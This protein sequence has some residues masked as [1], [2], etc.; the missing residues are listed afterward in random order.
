MSHS[1]I[2]ANIRQTPHPNWLYAVNG[3]L[4]DRADEGILPRESW[5]E[6]EHN[7]EEAIEINSQLEFLQWYFI[8][9]DDEEALRTCFV[10][11][12]DVPGDEDPLLY[13]LSD[14][15]LVCCDDCWSQE[16]W[17]ADAVEMLKDNTDFMLL[18]PTFQEH[19]RTKKRKTK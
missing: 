19:L 17:D 15:P 4:D 3:F 5:I 8:E 13:T 14:D 10:C 12:E 16:H 6:T 2:Q 7:L 9:L 1:E 18:V 11:E